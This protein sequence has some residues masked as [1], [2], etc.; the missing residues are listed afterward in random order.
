MRIRLMA[1]AIIN[2]RDHNQ[3]QSKPRE[4]LKIYKKEPAVDVV[5][6]RA[7][8][9][10]NRPWKKWMLRGRKQIVLNLCML[11]Y[12]GPGP[13]VEWRSRETKP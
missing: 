11:H 3:Q 12:P 1:I 13:R 9:R 2:E 5:C 6:G 7:G 4:E 8:P 10:N